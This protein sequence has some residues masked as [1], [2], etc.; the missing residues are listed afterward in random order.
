[1]KNILYLG[2]NAGSSG[3]H[4]LSGSGMRSAANEYVGSSGTGTFTQS[5]GTIMVTGGLS[6]G[7]SNSPLDRPPPD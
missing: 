3:I 2:Y 7:A 6:L 1:M 4:N 5:G